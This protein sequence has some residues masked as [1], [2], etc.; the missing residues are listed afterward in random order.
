VKKRSTSVTVR[1]TGSKSKPYT[2]GSPPFFSSL[3]GFV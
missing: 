1:H 2:A 3:I